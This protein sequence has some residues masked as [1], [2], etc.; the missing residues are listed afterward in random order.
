M[1]DS[2]SVLDSWLA[3]IPLPRVARRLVGLAGARVLPPASGT[4]LASAARASACASAQVTRCRRSGHESSGWPAV[5][6]G[7]TAVG[8]WQCVRK[9]LA[10]ASIELSSRR[11]PAKRVRQACCSIGKPPC[12]MRKPPCPSGEPL[13]GVRQP[14]ACRSEA[15]C[16]IGATANCPGKALSFAGKAK[17]LARKPLCSARK[18]SRL[19]LQGSDPCARS[20]KPCA[21]GRE[22]CT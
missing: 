16:S 14:D 5:C 13:I 22:A 20:A 9:S 21:Q 11:Q 12:S 3:V 10:P 15:L 19:A 17:S 8:R 18:A 4:S 6:P 2:D 7:A 1:P